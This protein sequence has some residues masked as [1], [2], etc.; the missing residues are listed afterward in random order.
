MYRV[1]NFEKVSFEQFHEA[2]KELFYV[3][4][5]HHIMIAIFL[6]QET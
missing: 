6:F 2:M 3:S 5:C 1:G 4:S